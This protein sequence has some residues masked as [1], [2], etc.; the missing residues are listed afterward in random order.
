ML[1]SIDFTDRLRFVEEK[2]LLPR[3]LLF[4]KFIITFTSEVVGYL[5][6]KLYTNK[7][8]DVGIKKTYN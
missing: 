4:L 5:Y 3:K 6:L 2:Q 1:S 8:T 7:I